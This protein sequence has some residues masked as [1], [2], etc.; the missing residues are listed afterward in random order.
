MVKK[1]LQILV[2]LFVL[3]GCSDKSVT[4]MERIQPEKLV[5]RPEMINV[6]KE[7]HLAEAVTSTSGLT[8]NKS[9][10]RFKR[11]KLQ[12]FNKYNLDSVSFQ[13]NFDYYMRDIQDLEYIYQALEDSFLLRKHHK[14]LD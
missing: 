6:L 1:F 9:L 4:K 13:E 10:A 7:I 2:Y 3:V 5:S 11:Y 8:Y 14:N 12:I